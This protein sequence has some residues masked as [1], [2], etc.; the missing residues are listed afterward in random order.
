MLRRGTSWTRSAYPAV[1]AEGQVP[2]FFLMFCQANCPSRPVG[3]VHCAGAIWL[4]S[5]YFAVNLFAGNDHI[6]SVDA[7]GTQGTAQTV[8][9]APPR[10]LQIIGG[11]LS[12][13]L[14]RTGIDLEDMF[15]IN[16]V[17]PMNFR[18][19]TDQ[20]DCA[21]SDADGLEY[22]GGSTF[23]AQLWLFK[24]ESPSEA[25]GLLANNDFSF[26]D[27]DA[28][29]VPSA[30]DG[31]G[32][33]VSEA[34]CYLLAISPVNWVPVDGLGNAI[35]NL[36]G[37]AEVSGPDGPGGGNAHFGW[38]GST[39]AFL[40]SCQLPHVGEGCYTIILAGTEGFGPDVDCPAISRRSLA[41]FAILVLTLGGWFTSD[42]RRN[43][44]SVG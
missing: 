8:F 6:E 5:P 38:S 11:R 30:N 16:I 33:M 41:A 44:R 27:S 29:L 21:I 2:S 37:I 9:K 7:G 1:Q 23:D 26:A 28:I 24:V 4:L 15:L 40:G 17:D 25:K 22:C 19:S 31:S 36:A 43:Q 14:L 39:P 13:S 34:G 10:N 42:R 3:R 12:S 32:A 18:A 20:A 35:F